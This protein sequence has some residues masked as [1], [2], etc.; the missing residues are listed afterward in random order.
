MVDGG[1][2]VSHCW[3]EV[4]DK[5]GEKAKTTYVKRITVGDGLQYEF[6]ISLI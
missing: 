4:S 5:Q 6:T 1:S 3:V 2:W